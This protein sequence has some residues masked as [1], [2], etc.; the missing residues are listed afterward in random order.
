MTLHRIYFDTNAG[1]GA[2]YDLGLR[3]SL[4]DIAPISDQLQ[5]GMRVVIYMTGE[6]EMEATLEFDQKYGRWMARPIEGTTKIYPEAYGPNSVEA[7]LETIERSLSEEMSKLDLFAPSDLTLRDK[8]VS[9]DVAMAVILDKYLAPDLSP[10]VSQRHHTVVFIIIGED[11]EHASPSLQP[12]TRTEGP[13]QPIGLIG[14]QRT[15]RRNKTLAL[16][17]DV[18]DRPPLPGEEPGS[19][20]GHRQPQPGPEPQAKTIPSQRFPREGFGW[21]MSRQEVRLR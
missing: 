11:E 17:L 13:A 18:A 6:L 4:E 5:D 1:D 15:C 14:N 2:R 3:G 8:P 12:P 19:G 21:R 7:L 20:I 9:A 10:L 16:P